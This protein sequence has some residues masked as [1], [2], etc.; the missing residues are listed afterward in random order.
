MK[1]KIE[2]TRAKMA[3]GPHAGGVPPFRESDDTV[4]Y[5][6]R[7]SKTAA[8]AMESNPLNV[9][10]KCRVLCP[11]KCGRIGLDARSGSC[12]QQMERALSH[13]AQ[14]RRRRGSNFWWERL[15]GTKDRRGP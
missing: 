15:V 13:Y 5:R 14:S 10:Q 4:K 3:Y 7:T 12:K 6:R 11:A 9:L 8:E 1:Q 2:C